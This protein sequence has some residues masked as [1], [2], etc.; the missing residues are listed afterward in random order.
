[1]SYF[2]AI[3]IPVLDFLWSLSVLKDNEIKSSEH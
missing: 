1:M 3:D 2:G